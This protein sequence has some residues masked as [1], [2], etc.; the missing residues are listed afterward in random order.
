LPGDACKTSGPKSVRVEPD[1]KSTKADIISTENAAEIASLSLI[2]FTFAASLR[3][4]SGADILSQVNIILLQEYCNAAFL[5]HQ[6]PEVNPSR[7]AKAVAI[8]QD[9][10]Q[11]G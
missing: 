11:T 6:F 7:R 1:P 4:T 3:L 9:G 5:R 8:R 2:S 10:I